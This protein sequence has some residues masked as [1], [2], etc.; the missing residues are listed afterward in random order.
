MKNLFTLGIAAMLV[1]TAA[2]CGPTSVVV[3][4]RPAPPVIVR[5]APPRPGYVW[6]EGEW[7]PRGGHYVW[8]NGYWTK[9]HGQRN[10]QSGHWERTHGGWYWQKGY[11][12]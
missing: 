2:S 11:W 3:T 4:D 10:W 8:Q 6:V 9:P 5:P 7:V 12:R 1:I